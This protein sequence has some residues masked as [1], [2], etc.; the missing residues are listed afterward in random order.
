MPLYDFSCPKCGQKQELFVRSYKIDR[1]TCKCGGIMFRL[2]PRIGR[3]KM[4]YPIFVDRIDD[5]QK[6][7]ED[8]GEKVTLP[9]PKEV[10]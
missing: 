5:I 3:I 7:Q 1:A 6:R 4:G 2:P 10:L 9:H 8:R